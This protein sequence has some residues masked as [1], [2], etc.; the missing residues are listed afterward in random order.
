MRT[1]DQPLDDKKSNNSKP[2]SVPRQPLE[3]ES[4]LPALVVTEVE[5]IS[6]SSKIANAY[7]IMNNLDC[8]RGEASTTL[9]THTLQKECLSEVYGDSSGTLVNNSSDQ[10]QDRQLIQFRELVTEAD[11]LVQS[12]LDK[13]KALLQ[14]QVNIVIS[15]V[16]RKKIQKSVIKVYLWK[17]Q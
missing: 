6:D 8:E 16:T 4:S 5:F 17:S 12:M 13:K 7:K 2:D 9:G 15:I 14:L 10:S 11:N 1:T 3:T